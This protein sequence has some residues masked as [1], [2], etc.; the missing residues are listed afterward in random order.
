M[1]RTVWI[2]LGLALS[3]S[4]AGCGDGGDDAAAGFSFGAVEY[5]LPF[6]PGLSSTES[7]VY[8]FKNLTSSDATI[9][10]GAYTPGGTLYPGG[11]M[12]VLIPARGETR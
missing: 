1:R 10:V 5:A 3:L 9:M 11:M 2:V 7:P 4:F 12:P 6:L 8:G